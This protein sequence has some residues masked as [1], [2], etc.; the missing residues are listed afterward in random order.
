MGF[1][2]L[3][4][5]SNPTDNEWLDLLARSV[6]EKVTLNGYCPRLHSHL[7]TFK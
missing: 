1:D 5:V 2:T 4:R 7:K 3:E 6:T